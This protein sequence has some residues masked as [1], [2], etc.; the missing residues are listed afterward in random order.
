MNPNL[1]Q[2]LRAAAMESRRRIEAPVAKSQAIWERLLANFPLRPGQWLCSYVDIEPEVRTTDRLRSWLGPGAMGRPRSAVPD[3]GR[4]L[5]GSP[6]IVVP[7]CRPRHLELFHLEDWSELQ[8]SRFGLLE[9]RPELRTSARQVAPAAIDLFLVPGLAFDRQGNRLGYGKGYYDRLLKQ[10]SS[11]SLAV[12]LAFS[13]QLVPSVPVA[14]E[15]DVPVDFIITDR[16]LLDCRAARCDW[17]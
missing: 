15:W 5:S 6:R 8:P 7:Y 12:A 17:K 11:D 16:E 10:R 3:E 4:S 2:A 9:P 14:A 13:E 1:K